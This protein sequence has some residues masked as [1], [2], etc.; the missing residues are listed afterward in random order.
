M[1]MESSAKRLEVRALTGESITV[2]ICGSKTVRDLKHLLKQTF[3]LASKYAN[4]N[5]YHKVDV[6]ASPSRLIRGFISRMES[7]VYRAFLS[8][9]QKLMLAQDGL[10]SFASVL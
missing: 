10:I 4:F 2:P 1:S 8:S 7:A 6:S 9:L 3:P 5:L